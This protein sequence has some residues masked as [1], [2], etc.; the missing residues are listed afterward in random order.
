MIKNIVF[1]MGNVLIMYSPERLLQNAGVT[2]ED[3]EILMKNMFRSIHWLQHDR[4]LLTTDALVETVCQNIPPHLHD[5][6]KD[7]CHNWHSVVPPFPEME[8]LIASLKENGYNIYLLSNAGKNLHS[9][10]GNIPAI[11]HFDGVF[12]SADYGLLKPDL[13]IYQKFC[14]TFNAPAETC[15]FV[16]DMPVNIEAAVFYGMRGHVFSGDVEALKADLKSA[17]VKI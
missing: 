9:Y 12:V 17:G 3:G 11:A 4:G 7:I 8:A 10:M 14:E 13:A 6:C 5:V 16:D 15:F 1:D 2:K